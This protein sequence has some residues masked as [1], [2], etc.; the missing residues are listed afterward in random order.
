MKI[1]L[2]VLKD[3]GELRR[4]VPEW[5]AL[6]AEAADPN[7][8]YEH[9]MLLPALAAYGTPQGFRAVAVT[10]DGR[11]S[12]FF[13]LLL[14]PRWRKIPVRALLSWRHRNML[15]GTPLLR[16][17]TAAPCL[18][19]LLQ[20]GLAPV[21]EFDWSAADGAFYAALA[22]AAGEAGLHWIVS[23]AYARAVLMRDSDPRGRFNSNMKN[24]VRRWQARLAAHGKLSAVRLGPEDDVAAWLEDFLRLEASGWKGRSGSALACR[25]DDRRFVSEVFPEAF[26]RGRLVITGLD[27]EGRALAR[28]TMLLGGEGAF[29]FK[30]AYDEA[31][32][33]ASPGILAEVEHVRQFLELP[34]PRWIDSNTSRENTSYGRVWKDRRVVQRIAIGATGV[35][36]LAVAALPFLRLAKRNVAGRSEAGAD[37]ARRR[38]PSLAGTT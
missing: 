28:H 10:V 32:A 18:L 13:P 20:S 37:R 36:R 26:R 16:A 9:W 4:L 14:Q 7:P 38:A 1:S 35:G 22:D 6:A 5:E 23:D 24:N 12:A 11:L 8:F 19:A 2:Q 33:S 29:T 15:V 34:G 21:V 31:Y 27:L 30:I 3:A 17:K 25:E